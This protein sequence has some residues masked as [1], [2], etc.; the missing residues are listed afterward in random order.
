MVL[1]MK[2]RI[3]MLKLFLSKTRELDDKE[4]TTMMVLNGLYSNKHDYLF[5]SISE[6]AYTLTGSWID[7]RIN[8]RRMYN[9]IKETL[10][11][12]AKRKIITIIDQSGNNYVISNDSLEVNTEKEK[13]VVVELWE[14]QKIFSESNKP[15]NVFTFFVNLVGTINAKTKEWHMSQNEMAELWG[16]SKRTVNDYLEQL[17]QMKLIYVYRHKKRRADGT[18]YKLNNSYGRYCDKTAIISEAQEYAD[19]VESEDFCENTNRRAIKLRY[20]AYCNGAKKYR[21]DP[22]AIMDLYRECKAYNKSLKF[23]PVEGSDSNGEWKQGELLDL[24]VFPEEIR[25]DNDEWG[26]ADPMD[27]T[28]GES[29]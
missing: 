11:K 8:D 12:L 21:D 15:F 5:T 7:K 24:S 29:Q 22:A 28:E 18:Y 9:S 26:E 14:M 1:G 17:S 19:K 6:I 23:K 2:G 16:A 3:I 10:S 27:N 4:L 25:N 20:N 13:F